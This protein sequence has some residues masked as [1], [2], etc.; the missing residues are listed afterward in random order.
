MGIRAYNTV[1]EL[2]VKQAA[3]LNYV[4]KGGNMIVQYNTNRRL[5]T[6]ENLAPYELK[7]SRKR[8]TDES[9]EVT[10]L[11]PEHELMNFPNKIE[12]KDFDGWVQERGLYFPES[13]SK[14]FTPLF[15][16]T[17]NGEG[18]MEGSLLVAKYGKGHYIYT[19]LSFFREL[20]AGVPGAYKLF[21]NMIS[22]G[23]NDLESEIKK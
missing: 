9:A 3:L 21:T 12:K 14:K 5:V 18:P 20:P 1:E 8:I 6:E 2:A 23:R 17:E 11:A 4:R 16:F 10:F 7:L 22:I 13:W 19:G 15:S